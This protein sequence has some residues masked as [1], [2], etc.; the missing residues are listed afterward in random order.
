MISLVLRIWSATGPMG[1]RPPSDPTGPVRCWGA[2]ERMSASSRVGLAL[3]IWAAAVDPADVPMIKSASVTSN[4]ASNR[5]AMTPIN[6]ALPADPPP[7][8]TNARS[9]ATR[10][11][12]V[13]STCSRSWSDLGL[14]A[15]VA[16]GKCRVEKGVVSMGVASRELPGGRSRWRLPKSRDRALQRSTHCGYCLHGIHLLPIDHDQVKTLAWR[17]RDRQPASCGFPGRF[18]N[19]PMTAT[20]S[21]ATGGQ[22]TPWGLGAPRR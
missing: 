17:R 9:S 12:V 15:A 22:R 18:S 11:R 7:P 20:P 14:S 19:A 16:E 2:A 10:S 1:T 13:A 6:H 3:V 4:P 8:R 21:S 5:P